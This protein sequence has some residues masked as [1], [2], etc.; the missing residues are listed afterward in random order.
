[1]I[2]SLPRLKSLNLYNCKI[3]GEAVSPLAKCKGLRDLRGIKLELSSDVFRAIGGN[4]VTLQCKLG[5]GG[6]EEIVE[7]CPN[8]EHLNIR[9]RDI[10]VKV[11]GEALD[12]ETLLL[13]WVLKSGLKKLSKLVINRQ[14]I[15]LGTD[16]D[17]DWE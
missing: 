4:L 15:R 5:S 1:V 7:Y 9:D 10:V 6:P 12:D 16:W 17:W 8:Q 2:A 11:E 3:D 13:A 14:T